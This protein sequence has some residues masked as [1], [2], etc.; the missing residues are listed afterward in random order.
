MME[1][2]T[3]FRFIKGDVLFEKEQDA[4]SFYIVKR[5]TVRIEI[6]NENDVMIR[7]GEYF[8]ETAFLCLLNGTSKRQRMGRAMVYD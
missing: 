2:T 3:L 1:N 8:G 4:N 6:F 7:E 5:G